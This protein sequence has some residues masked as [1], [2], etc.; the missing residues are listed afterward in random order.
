MLFRSSDFRRFFFE[1]RPEDKEIVFYAE[2][3][4]YYPYY[5]GLIQ[6]LT[7]QGIKS[8]CY[9]TSD[10][11]DPVLHSPPPGVKPYYLDKLMLLFMIL[12][13]CKVF[14]MTLTD[15]DNLHYR[16]SSNPVHYV[17]VFHSPISTHA[18]YL[19]GAFDNYDA[20]FCVCP[21]HVKELKTLEK[22]RGTKPKI[23]LET[24]YYRVERIRKKAD[25]LIKA[26]SPQKTVLIAPSWGEGNIIESCG[27]VLV[28]S[29][30]DGNFRVILRP[31]PEIIKRQPGLIMEMNQQFSENPNYIYENSVREDDSL[32]E[33]D[34]L[35]SDYSGIAIEYAIGT[36]RP[37]LYIDVPKK[38]KNQDFEKTG[39]PVIEIEIRSKTGI[40]ITP[41]EAGQAAAKTAELIRDKD[42]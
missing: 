35:I 41:E 30:L 25:K 8:I 14:L 3:R 12:V 13:D 24:G 33:A 31:H 5:E 34:L 27:A 39:L 23:L 4:G 37:V 17:Y 40:I 18:A 26:E 38:I 42:K 6:A 29:L 11:G 19:H 28:K 7:G 10:G 9:V 16:R 15:L 36:L 22:Q 20:G 32:I 2:H 1:C 21:H